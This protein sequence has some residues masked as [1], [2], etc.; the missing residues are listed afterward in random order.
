MA[1]VKRVIVYG[2]SIFLSGIA[3]LLRADAGLEIVEIRLQGGEIK[4]KNSQ[5]DV[6]LVDALQTSLNQI[7]ALMLSF[8]SRPG[9]PFIS[10]NADDKQLTVLSSQQYPAVNLPNLTQ[11]IKNFP[12]P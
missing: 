9:L 6:V 10:L 7:S 2:D 5:P 11:V 4:L 1:H 8:H 12:N 3:E